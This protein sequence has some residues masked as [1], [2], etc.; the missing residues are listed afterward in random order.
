MLAAA[1]LDAGRRDA[2]DRIGAQVD[3]RHVRAVEGLEVI[4]VDR[5]TLRRVGMI[6]VGECR[7]GGRV[8]D[9]GANARLEEFGGGVVRRP[10][11]QQ[12]VEGG[13]ELQPA[14]LPGR[15][16]DRLPLL[17]RH[18][19]H[20][21]LRD[22]ERVPV[23]GGLGDAADLLELLAHPA[24]EFRR[25]RRVA[26]RHAVVR[27][28][29]EHGEVRRGLRDHGRGLD[30]GRAGADLPDPLARE[31]HALVRPLAGVDP[32]AAEI[33]QA[34]DVRHVGRRQAPHRGDEV[35]RRAALAGFG[36]DLPA[37]RGL[38]EARGRHAHAEADVAPQVELAGDVIQVGAD[39]RR[40]RVALARFPL[41]AQLAREEVAV[42][43]A[44][45]V[46]AR[47][48]VAVPVPGAAEVAA[49][50]EHLGA[51]PQAIAQAM[52]LVEP[53]ESRADDECVE[54]HPDGNSILV[55][56]LTIR[57]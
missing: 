37:V 25:Q 10:V 11:G 53:R 4:G 17:G 13:A 48:R 49:R 3:Q 35:G 29:L 34:R 22:A 24:L 1:G 45:G 20:L 52:E 16:V 32:L 21:A 7:R 9:D 54:M 40:A 33:L 14:G 55:S 2:L 39:L 46:A 19:G 44:F 28:A 56:P 18:L 5:R 41:V 6:D 23:D 42:G 31:I 47:P 12:V 57:R 15:V 26:R 27:G 38:V 51:Q 36:L 8:L 30:A 50:L 43:M